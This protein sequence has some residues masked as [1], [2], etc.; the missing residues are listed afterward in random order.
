MIPD[1]DDDDD[2]KGSIRV[3]HFDKKVKFGDDPV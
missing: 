3:V 1:D 2:A